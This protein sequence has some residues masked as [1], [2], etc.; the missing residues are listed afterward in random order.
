MAGLEKAQAALLAPSLP[1]TECPVLP[2]AQS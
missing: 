2:D 1:P